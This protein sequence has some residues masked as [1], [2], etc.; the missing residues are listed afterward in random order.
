MPIANRNVITD[1]AAA[2]D[3]ARA[4]AATARLNVEINL[5]SIAD[6]AAGTRFAAAVDGV[7]ALLA[8]ADAISAEVRA[9]L[10]R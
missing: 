7:D 8:H 3:A 6:E 2:A 10:D 9:G 1:V 5:G 4:A